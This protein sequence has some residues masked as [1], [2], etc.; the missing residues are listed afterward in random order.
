M[1]RIIIT[2]VAAAAVL[3]GGLATTASAMASTGPNGQT[4]QLTGSSRAAAYTDPFFGPVQCNETQHAQFDTV[5]CK[6][7]VLDANGNAV[8]GSS[9]SLANVT[10]GEISSVGWN[11]DFGDRAAT[12]VLSFTVSAD[13]LSYTGQATYPNG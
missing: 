12:G 11:S 4:G 6:G 2:A 10:P 3:G 8:K 13:G 7:V 9:A 5:S 1:K